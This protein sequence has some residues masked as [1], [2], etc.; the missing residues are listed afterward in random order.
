ADERLALEVFIRARR[1]SDEHQIRSRVPDAEDNLAP[2]E[3]MQFAAGAVADIRADGLRGLSGRGRER[4]RDGLDCDVRGGGVP[5]PPS[6]RRI[7]TDAVDTE[8]MVE[9]QM[10]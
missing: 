9:T 5:T 2:P 1:L 6:P 8:F 3:P 10:F 4:E 7:T